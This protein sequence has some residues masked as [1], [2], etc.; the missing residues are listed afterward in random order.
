KMFHVKHFGTILEAEYSRPHITSGL[1]TCGI[2]R[3]IGIL[4]RLMVRPCAAAVFAPE[5]TSTAMQQCIRRIA[6]I[7][8]R[9]LVQ[10]TLASVQKLSLRPKSQSDHF[11]HAVGRGAGRKEADVFSGFI[12]QVDE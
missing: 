11:D 5:P 10:G 7:W 1:E 6:G 2:A 3:K 12:D 9:L 4:G 8:S